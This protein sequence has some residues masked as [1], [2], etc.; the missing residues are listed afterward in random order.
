MSFSNSVQNWF[1]ILRKNHFRCFAFTCF[2]IFLLLCCYIISDIH[3]M[4]LMISLKI[5]NCDLQ[6]NWDIDLL[7]SQLLEKLIFWIFRILPHILSISKAI[8]ITILCWKLRYF[9]GGG[10]GGG[11]W[12]KLLMCES[13]IFREIL[14]SWFYIFTLK[15]FQAYLVKIID[16]R[17]L[18]PSKLSVSVSALR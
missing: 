14:F 8:H 3:K 12:L 1:V 17:I 4:T 11:S 16:Q 7:G 2:C 6:G 13:L 5:S 15:L 9:F 18:E 10:R